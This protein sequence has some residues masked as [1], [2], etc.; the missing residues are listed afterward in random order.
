MNSRHGGYDP[1]WM[2]QTEKELE[3]MADD[4]TREIQGWNGPETVFTPEEFG[5][6]PG[7]KATSAIQQA[8]DAAAVNGGIVRLS[9]GKYVSGTIELRSGV[10]LEICAGSELL[11]STDLSDY[12]E[13]HA[14]R[15]TVQD[16]SMGM[17]QSLIFAEGCENI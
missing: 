12:P 8:V 5:W 4:L 6:I 2:D 9:R 16:T 11:G 7:E 1:A 10:C 3:A 14:K 13:H 17:H 15:L